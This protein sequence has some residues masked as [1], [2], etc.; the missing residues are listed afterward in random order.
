MRDEPVHSETTEE[1]KKYRL[2]A[3]ASVDVY[4]VTCEQLS[5]NRTDYEILDAVI[6]GGTKIIQLR[7][8]T[9]TKRHLY[10]KAV[11][12]REVT[13]E[14]SVLLIINDHIE[15]AAAVKAD[16]V[17]LGQEDFPARVAKQL[18]PELIIG[19]S[20]HSLK[21]ALQAE[22]DGADYLNIGPIFPTQTKALI[23]SFLGPES[24]KTISQK[25]SIPFTVMGGINASNLDSVLARGARKIAMVTAITMA[26]DISQTVAE[27]KQRIATFQSI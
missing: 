4:P 8:K 17:H 5:N 23:G 11:R 12:F 7:D 14:A 18:F 10:E 15:I 20:T 24:V 9:A 22:L 19:V 2:H 6:E 16:G 1:I 21:D 27:F 13:R 25:I 26:N 3:F